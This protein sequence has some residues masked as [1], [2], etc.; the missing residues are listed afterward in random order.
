MEK[1]EVGAEQ[2]RNEVSSSTFVYVARNDTSS[3]VCA[4]V[5]LF[6]NTVGRSVHS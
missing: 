2:K 6:E 5:R 4:F 3:A 1:F